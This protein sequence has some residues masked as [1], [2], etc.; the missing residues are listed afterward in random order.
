M[1]STLQILMREW[2]DD[3]VFNS[4]RP[5][6]A[7]V[8]SCA[9]KE[10]LGITIAITSTTALLFYGIYSYCSQTELEENDCGSSLRPKF[11]LTYTR[12]PS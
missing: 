3:C 1:E 8:F 4:E 9:L 2:M 6:K 11:L 7:T 10:S 12:D 5:V